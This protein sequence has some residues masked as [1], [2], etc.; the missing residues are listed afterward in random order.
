MNAVI[1]RIVSVVD[2]DV[3][4]TR[5]IRTENDGL[6][7]AGIVANEKKLIESTQLGGA[8]V[9]RGTET[10]VLDKTVPP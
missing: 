2:V 5:V 9:G 1:F 8:L 4:P 7:P 3:K 6:E 10:W